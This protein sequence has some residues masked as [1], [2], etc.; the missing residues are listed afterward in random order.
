MEEN[1][2]RSADKEYLLTHEDIEKIMKETLI[3]NGVNSEIQVT[4]RRNEDQSTS[5]NMEGR[6]AN[7]EQKLA[8]K[9]KKETKT[10]NSD[11]IRAN[12]DNTRANVN[13]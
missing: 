8:F 13:G 4:S 11:N 7:L 1:T 9:G 10:S 6:L 5:G 3:D 2:Y 12:S